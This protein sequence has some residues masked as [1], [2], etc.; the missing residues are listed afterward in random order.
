MHFHIKV[1]KTPDGYNGKHK[2]NAKYVS[3]RGIFCKTEKAGLFTK[4]S[5]HNWIAR[6][7]EKKGE[8]FEFKLIQTEKSKTEL[9]IIRGR[10]RV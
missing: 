10:L 5:A 6:F 1:I 4:D 7:L 8:G 9:E 2:L 3:N